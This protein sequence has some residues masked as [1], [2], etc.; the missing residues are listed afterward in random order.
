VTPC[1]EQSQTLTADAPGLPVQAYELYLKQDKYPD[2][3]R[4]ALRVNDRERIEQCF[5]ATPDPLEKQQLAFLLARQARL[6]L[7]Y[8]GGAMK[9]ED[10][11][12]CMYHC[13]DDPELN[14]L[15]CHSNAVHMPA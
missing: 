4:V 3:M 7:V 9:I 12:R 14:V 5:A 6:C 15:Q 1:D 2:A 13:Y 11:V 10:T 8:I